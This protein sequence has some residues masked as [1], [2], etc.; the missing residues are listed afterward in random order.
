V[1]SEYD[2]TLEETFPGGVYKSINGGT[3]WARGSA[4]FGSE[5]NLDIASI[6]IHPNNHNI[7][8]AAT[9]DAPTT[10]KAVVEVFFIKVAMR[11]KPGRLSITDWAY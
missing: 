6:A 10:I 8:Y 5:E 7:L 2:H 9:S 3:S 4:G 1:S 11:E